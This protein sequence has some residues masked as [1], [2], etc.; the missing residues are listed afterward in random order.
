M[1]DCE[2]I[3]L[4]SNLIISKNP[5]SET[6]E[7]IDLTLQFICGTIKGV[8]SAFNMECN[9]SGVCRQ[10]IVYNNLLSY[11]SDIKNANDTANAGPSGITFPYSFTITLITLNN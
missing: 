3:R 8:I 1:L 7:K 9:V 4:H 2:E 6:T 10:N 5:S 11:T